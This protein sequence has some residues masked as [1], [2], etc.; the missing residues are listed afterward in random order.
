MS[1]TTGLTPTTNNTYSMEGKWLWYLSGTFDTAGVI[2]VKIQK[3]DRY[4]IGY[5]FQPMLTLNRM[6]PKTTVFGMIDEY[7]E[8]HGI[9]YRIEEQE[10][11]SNRLVIDD[12]ESIK[13]F[14]EPIIGGF[15][16]QREQAEVML[17]EIIPAM[18]EGKHREKEGFY[19]MMDGVETLREASYT[20]KKSK[21]TKDY[22]K[23]EWKMS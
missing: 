23:K 12:L 2:T 5:D 16:Q 17:T 8:E 21:Y 4:T 15:I 13:R 20:R 14:L 11:G 10:S 7:A 18:E 9:K 6:E 19:E 1:T 22:F 3:D